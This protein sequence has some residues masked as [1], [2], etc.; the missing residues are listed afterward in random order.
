MFSVPAPYVPPVLSAIKILNIAN[1]I[2][3]AC[4]QGHKA[5]FQKLWY[6]DEGVLHTPAQVNALLVEMDAASPGQ[7]TK[8][9]TTGVALVN[10]ILADTPDALSPEEWM[11]PYEYTV[12]PNTFALRVHA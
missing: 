2:S 6:T 10:L 5:I 4:I 7:S 1:E 12:D 3:N 8:I 9:F 11:P